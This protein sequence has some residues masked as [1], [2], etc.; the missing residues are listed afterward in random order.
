VIDGFG[1]LVAF[2]KASPV[3]V[4]RLVKKYPIRRLGGRRLVTFKSWVEEWI[5]D[6]PVRYR[7]RWRAYGHLER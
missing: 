2:L 4:R 5:D 1:E 6:L 7:S 3:T